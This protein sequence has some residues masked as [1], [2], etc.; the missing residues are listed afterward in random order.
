MLIAWLSPLPPTASGI[1]DYSFELLPLVAEGAEVEAFSPGRVRAPAG[2][3]VRDPAEFDRLA[4]RYDVVFHH[5]GNNPFHAFVYRAA[6]RHP[7]VAVLHEFVLH[8][9]IDHL[10]FGEGRHD[11]DSYER[12]ATAEY[13]EI[14]SRLAHLH[15]VGAFTEF[16]RFVFPLSGH[17]VRTSTAAVVH[18]RFAWNHVRDAH[19]DIAVHV[20]PHHAG[21]LPPSV[22]QVT[23]EEARRRL[24]LSPDAFLVGQFGFITR[25]KQPAAVLGGFSKLLNRKADA[26]LLVIGENQLGVG[27]ELLLERRRLRERVELTG[28]VDLERFALYLKAVDVVVNLRYPSAGEASGTFTRALAVGRATI[29]SNLGSFA[30]YPEGVCLRVEVD[31]DQADEVGS[32]LIRLAEDPGFKASIEQRALRYAEVQLD[33][34]RCARMYLDVARGMAARSTAAG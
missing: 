10:L 14:G 34:R 15:A 9:L 3:L 20:I 27:M 29:V 25:P 18:A 28:Y 30:E 22:G 2:I 11:L 16:E 13:G 6:L 26:R 12:L 4:D 31:G 32:H 8:H 19:P 33:P 24:G 23:R 21:R 7:G 17:V 5:L 1:A